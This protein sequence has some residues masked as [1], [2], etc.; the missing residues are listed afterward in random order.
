MNAPAEPAPPSALVTVTVRAPVLAPAS[1]VT[2]AVSSVEDLNV[3][4]LT[5]MPEPKDE[6]APLVKPLPLIATVWATAPWPRE[7]GLVLVTVGAAVIVKALAEPVPPSALVTETVRAPVLAPASI[8]MLAVS[9]V[10]DLSV[11]ELTVTPAPKEA[12]APLV[13]PEPLIATV[14]PTAPWPRELGLVLETVGAA[15]TEKIAEPVP[16]PASGFVTVTLREPTVAFA[17]IVIATVSSVEDLSVVEL[18]VTPLPEKVAAAP[19]AKCVPA[20]VTVW[21]PEP[22]PREAGLAAATVGLEIAVAA[23]AALVA[24]HDLHTAVTV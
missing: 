3:V 10:E 15:V 16:A 14:C 1:I 11:V 12:V 17:A 5:A 4:E 18:T 13:K 19:P 2:L 9:S 24:V 7:L 20:I 23:L 21:A 6:V 8:V 22:W